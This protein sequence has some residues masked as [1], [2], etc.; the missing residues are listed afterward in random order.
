[1]SGNEFAS[2]RTVGVVGAGRMG[3]PI[4]GH[5]ARKGFVV[6]VHDVDAG[7]RTAV[8]SQGGHWRAEP[9]GL[10]RESDA[11]LVCVG[12]DRE[13]RELLAAD[14]PLLQSRAGT[15][16]AILSTVLPATVRELAERAGGRGIHV[17]DATVCRG[18]WAADEGTLLSFVAG[19]APVVDRLRPVLSAYS[20]DIVP[21]GSVGSAQVAKAVNNMIM[22][23]CLV[24]NHEGLALAHR[25]GLDIEA[26]RKALMTTH[27]A[28]KS[29]ELWGQQTMAWADDD[30]EIVAAMAK[31]C[32]LTL[33][34][35]RAVQAICR[36]LKPHRFQLD[37]Y[38]K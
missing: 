15:I 1:M 21:T 12:Y 17:V 10:A 29:L 7:K 33:R 38:G 30:M 32:G 27:S 28:N 23:A 19:D 36:E 8:E 3:Q 20:S 35:A 34:Q 14:G 11:I 6:L 9:A 24:A 25:Y 16:V 13:I 22:W 2:I 26:M 31:D 37:K 18:S 5:L 4:I